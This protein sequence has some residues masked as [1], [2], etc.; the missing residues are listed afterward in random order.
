MGW[1]LGMLQ[2]LTRLEDEAEALQGQGLRYVEARLKAL[3]YLTCWCSDTKET[4]WPHV[5][6]HLWRIRALYFGGCCFL[7]H[8]PGAQPHEP[9]WKY[10]PPRA[11]NGCKVAPLYEREDDG[12]APSL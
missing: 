3:N 6:R 4:H 11:R 7:A 1:T 9:I 12:Q 5:N 2:H 8:W 10:R